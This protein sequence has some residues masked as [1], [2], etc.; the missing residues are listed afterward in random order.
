MYNFNLFVWL[1]SLTRIWNRIRTER[2]LIGSRYTDPHWGKSWLRI[3]IHNV[4]N[5][6]CGH[7]RKHTRCSYQDKN[8]PYCLSM[9]QL[10]YLRT[11]TRTLSLILR[12]FGQFFR[13]F[14]LRFATYPNWLKVCRAMY[15]QKGRNFGGT[16]IFLL[17]VLIFFSR[18][19]PRNR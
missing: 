8:L 14:S 17:T 19:V 2:H 18:S 12:K 4:G 15:D 16:Q 3:R 1:Q 5:F 13:R 9:I 11:T 7:V 10:T 6:T